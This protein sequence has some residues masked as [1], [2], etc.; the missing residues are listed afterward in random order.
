MKLTT[1][2]LRVLAEPASTPSSAKLVTRSVLNLLLGS[3]TAAS[4]LVGK[5]ERHERGARVAIP[6]DVLTPPDIKESFVKQVFAET[7]EIWNAAGITFTW[8]RVAS[9]EPTDAS[10][11]R[12]AIERGRLAAGGNHT[13]LGW[14]LFTGNA[15]EASIHL[16]IGGAE[17]LLDEAED[18]QDAAYARH[19]MLLERALGRAL[20]HEIGHYLL[21]TKVHT[22][23]GL[24]RASWPPQEI[25]AEG[26]Q[27]FQLTPEQRISAGAGDRTPA[28]CG[29]AAIEKGGR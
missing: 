21:G 16:S 18:V 10:R 3:N 9:A 7:D 27:G 26:R 4:D 2:R 6:V 28:G 15:P 5:P 23:R 1:G 24:M 17:D 11:L 22:Q 14:I 19:E 20:S 25:F 8:H 29:S 13:A 12:V